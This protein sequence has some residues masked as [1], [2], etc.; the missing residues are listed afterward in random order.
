MHKYIYSPCIRS[1]FIQ[2][3]SHLVP[4]HCIGV[5]NPIMLSSSPSF[6]PSVMVEALVFRLLGDWCPPITIQ[7]KGVKVSSLRTIEYS[8]ITPT[9]MYDMLAVQLI[10]LCKLTFLSSETRRTRGGR[11]VAEIFTVPH[12]ISTV[13]YCRL[14]SVLHIALR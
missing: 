4:H 14:A 9:T 1:S 2:L 13:V 6:D 8:Y 10:G 11:I 12:V 7:D 3:C 5:D